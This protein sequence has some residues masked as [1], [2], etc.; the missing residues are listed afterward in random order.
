MARGIAIYTELAAARNVSPPPSRIC[1]DAPVHRLASCKWSSPAEKVTAALVRGLFQR[2]QR[3][4]NGRITHEA[5]NNI[6]ASLKSL[7]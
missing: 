3:N 5:A 4:G 1:D 7:E 2:H 6:G